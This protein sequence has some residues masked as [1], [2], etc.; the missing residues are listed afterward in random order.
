MK[1][2]KNVK[3]RNSIKLIIVVLICVIAIG[4]IASLSSSANGSSG[5]SSNNSSSIPDNQPPVNDS[6]TQNPDDNITNSPTQNP[7]DNI[8]NSPTQNPDGNV[9]NLISIESPTFFR[10]D[11]SEP[12]NWVA[13]ENSSALH[14]KVGMKFDG[15]KYGGVSIS[16]L[17]YDLRFNL[18]AGDFKEFCHPFAIIGASTEINGFTV[19]D[20]DVEISGGFDGGLVLHPFYRGYDGS[21][22]EENGFTS[23]YPVTYKDGYLIDKGTGDRISIKKHMDRDTGRYNFHMTV[24]VCAVPASYEDESSGENVPLYYNTYYYVNGEFMFKCSE[25]CDWSYTRSISGFWFGCVFANDS[26]Y[27]RWASFDNIAIRKIYEDTYPDAYKSL[28][29]ALVNNWLRLE[30]TESL[31]LKE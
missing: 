25:Q 19:F 30:F 21:D 4:V 7:D 1:K 31:I 8:T 26:N 14:S 28:G 11:F 6:P 15:E 5:I 22:M 23:W 17:S 3:K 29:Y 18:F 24:A 9:T 2:R 13:K 10:E 27:D 20:F 12:I 16:I